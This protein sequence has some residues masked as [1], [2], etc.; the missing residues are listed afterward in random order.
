MSEAT[1]PSPLPTGDCPSGGRFRGPGRRRGLTRPSHAQRS[2]L[3]HEGTILENAGT[4]RPRAGRNRSR[5]GL[6]EEGP[7]TFPLEEP[8]SAQRG[9]G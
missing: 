1:R 5:S 3:Q 8:G 2:G 4:P 6:R 9:F 7:L